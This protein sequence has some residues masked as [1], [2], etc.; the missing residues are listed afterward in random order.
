M[1][2]RT[3]NDGLIQCELSDKCFTTQVFQAQKRKPQIAEAQTTLQYSRLLYI[4]PLGFFWLY[5]FLLIYLIN[6]IFDK[7]DINCIFYENC[8][9]YKQ[10]FYLAFDF[11]CS[12]K[13][14]QPFC[15]GKISCATSKF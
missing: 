9:I 8:M 2:N 5:T 3:R 4:A 15:K 7:T 6:I 11:F 13:K 14:V 1:I 10:L 12:E